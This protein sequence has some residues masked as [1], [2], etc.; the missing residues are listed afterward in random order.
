[1][2]RYRSTAISEKPTL[3]PET[4]RHISERNLHYYISDPR[5]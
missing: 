1:V 2:V 5:I 3:V 4:S